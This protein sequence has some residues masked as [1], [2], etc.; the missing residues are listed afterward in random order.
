MRINSLESINN[1]IPFFNQNKTRTPQSVNNEN[2]YFIKRDDIKQSNQ[3]TTSSYL[4]FSLQN[5]TYRKKWLNIGNLLS[6]T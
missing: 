5:A 1:A 2:R 3:S 4:I 6:E